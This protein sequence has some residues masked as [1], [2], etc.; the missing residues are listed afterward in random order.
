M[1]GK[2]VIS[3][4]TGLEDAERVTVAFL[5]AVGAA[6][7][8]RPTLMFL[9]KEAVRLALRGVATGV[10]CAGCP[11][12]PDLVERY[13]NAGGT[14]LVCPICFNAKGLDETQ[15]IKSAEIGGTV[16]MWRWIG[17]GATT[18]SY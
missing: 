16:V 3:L 12:L 5:V 2:A 7:E 9:T 11:P 6:E 14:F 13:V 18:F 15:L 10:A 17:D 1:S 8:G 4:T